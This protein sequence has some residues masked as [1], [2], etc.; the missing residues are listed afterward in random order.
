MLAVYLAKIN[1]STNIKIIHKD[2]K[3]KTLKIGTK[4]N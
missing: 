3:N 2:F 1:I 4:V